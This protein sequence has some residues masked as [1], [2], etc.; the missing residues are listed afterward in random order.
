MVITQICPQINPEGMHLVPLP[1]ADDIR[2]PE[3]TVQVRHA[4]E[5]NR[6][7]KIVQVRHAKEV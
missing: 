1:F 6:G 4:K 3:K 7:F 5:V 2:A